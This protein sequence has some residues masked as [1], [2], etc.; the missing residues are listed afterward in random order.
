MTSTNKKTSRYRASSTASDDADELANKVVVPFVITSYSC[1]ALIVLGGLAALIWWLTTLGEN[2]GF[3]ATLSGFYDNE[4]VTSHY[5]CDSDVCFYEFDTG[6]A[7]SI[8]FQGSGNLTDT[9][10]LPLVSTF[11]RWVN[12]TYVKTLPLPVGFSQTLRVEND[13][14]KTFRISSQQSSP[15]PLLTGTSTQQ[16]TLSLR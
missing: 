7:V 8:S 4:N 10:G 15:S 16:T 14:S 9:D 6:F 3:Q 1:L 13:P 5:P 12:E 11:W 2:Q